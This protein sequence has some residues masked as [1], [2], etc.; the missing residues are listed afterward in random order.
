M[1]RVQS[2]HPLDLT[3]KVAIVTG[4]NRGIGLGIAKG[5]TAAGRNVAIWGRDPQRNSDAA[6]LCSASRGRAIGAPCDVTRSDSLEDALRVTTGRFGPANGI[7]ANA[8]T[9]GGG[10]KP[11]LEQSDEDWARVLEVNLLGAKRTL[12]TVLVEQAKAGQRGGRV[13]VTS[14][15]A[16]NFGTAYNQHYAASKSALVAL[17][18]RSL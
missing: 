11:F 4:G 8:G 13:V 12:A 15:V 16:A 5:L 9:G 10:R 18:A 2:A 1:T 14:S 3:G 17:A 6:A 7:F